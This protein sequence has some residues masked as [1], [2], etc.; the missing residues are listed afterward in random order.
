MRAKRLYFAGIPSDIPCERDGAH[1][2]IVKNTA[3]APE[4]QG[5]WDGPVWERAN[6]LEITCYHPKSSQHHP[7][8]RVRM[9]HDDTNIYLIF[10]V[11]DRFVR[12]IRTDY[13]AMVCCDSCVEFFVQPHPDTRGY[14]N[15]EINAIG[16]LLV[17]YVEDPTRCPDG[18]AKFARLP[19]SVGSTIRVFHSLNGVI[20][21]EIT[22]PVDWTVEYAIPRTLFEAY[23][24]PLGPLSGQ[25]WR[26]NFYKC[27]DETSHPHWGLLGAH[28][29]GA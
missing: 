19:W 15:F 28:R 16:T 9:L 18:F 25:V 29:R 7:R 5:A 21:P 1:D 23:L 4:L 17:S 26:A 2:L 6:E 11:A 8:V 22:E 14:F 3:E 12:C 27:A 20:Y 10:R 24:G 13:Q